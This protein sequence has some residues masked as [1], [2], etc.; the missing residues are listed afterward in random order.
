MFNTPLP[1][2]SKYKSKP[3]D[4]DEE[5]ELNNLYATDPVLKQFYGRTKRNNKKY[6]DVTRA[7]FPTQRCHVDLFDLFGNK[8]RR[9]SMN[10]NL[11]QSDQ[12]VRYGLLCI[13][14]YSRY[15]WVVGLPNKSA[16]ATLNGFKKILDF[17]QPYKIL[18]QWQPTL[19][20]SD[21][22]LEFTNK[23]LKAFLEEKGHKLITVQSESG[24][25]YLA[26]RC[27]RTYRS[28]LSVLIY[29]IR[30]LNQKK[31]STSIKQNVQL[32]WS[33]LNQM[34]LSTYNTTVHAAFN[35]KFSPQDVLTLKQS[36]IDYLN[37]KTVDIDN[38][39]Q[40][41]KILKKSHDPVS[42]VVGDFVYKAFIK[43]KTF[44]KA[45]ETPKIDTNV[46]YKVHKIRPPIMNLNKYPLYYLQTLKGRPLKGVY[47]RDSLVK[48]LQPP[49]QSKKKKISLPKR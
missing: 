42:L 41:V 23:T 28:L 19:F 10:Q 31:K 35:N 7:S 49:N 38:Y 21:K 45:S 15:A 32:K 39:T 1:L 9:I 43:P 11:L 6:Q 13:D 8:N 48:V 40:Y 47:R 44:T 14:C 12:H 3:P 36:T 33:S 46:I 30:Y 25:S 5:E 37:K 24:K 29:K 20:V 22:G 2:Y 18:R 27:I 4:S 26:E 17:M 34:V 16:D